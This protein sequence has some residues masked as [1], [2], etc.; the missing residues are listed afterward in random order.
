MRT[1]PETTVDLAAVVQQLEALAGELRDASRR[2]TPEVSAACDALGCAAVLLRSQQGAA[3]GDAARSD[4]LY[5]AVAM[6]RSAVESAKFACRARMG[7]RA[8]TSGRR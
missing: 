2:L 8:G 7:S 6:A 3:D 1:G 5:D 4:L